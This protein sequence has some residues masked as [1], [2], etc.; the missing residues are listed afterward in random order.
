MNECI[1]LNKN[2][3]SSEHSGVQARL[4]LHGHE[5]LEKKFTCVWHVDQ[6]NVF[7]R[8]AA[9]AVVDV[10]IE[11]CLAEKTTSMAHVHCVMI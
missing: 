11:Y 8:I 3:L 7:A 9:S 4:D 1:S 10:L 6:V 2:S 5:F